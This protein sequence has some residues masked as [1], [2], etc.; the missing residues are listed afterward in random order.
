MSATETLKA[1]S[2]RLQRASDFAWNLAYQV[3]D[4]ELA[5]LYAQQAVE[6]YESL[7]GPLPGAVVEIRGEVS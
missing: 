1:Y 5:E 2:E 7:F 6:V 3:E 4:G